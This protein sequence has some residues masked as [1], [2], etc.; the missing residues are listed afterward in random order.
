MRRLGWLIVLVV[1]LAAV[2]TAQ[3]RGPWRRGVDTGAPTLAKDE[4]EK[5]ILSVIEEV[6]RAGR[7]YASVPVTDGR[8]LRLLAE[9]TGA[10]HV[11]EVGTST[12]YSGLWLCLALQKTGGKLT[13][14]EIDSRRA[15]MAREHFKQAGVDRLVTLVEGDAHQTIERVKEPIDMVFLDADKDGYVTYLEKLL[16]L[17]RPGG[18]ILAHNVNMADEYVRRVT[19]DPALETVF[20]MQGG[21]LSITLK[22]R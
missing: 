17:V 16:P 13:T 22:K 15:A 11:V 6:E 2:I 1:A 12:G 3:R 5:R 18:L 20:Y 21:G 14:F 4:A 10:R 7:L 9:A 19:G 8:M